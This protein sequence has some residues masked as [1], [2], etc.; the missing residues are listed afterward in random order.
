MRV[1]V[2][3]PGWNVWLATVNANG[4]SAIASLWLAWPT[5]LDAARRAAP[6]ATPL[7][8]G[9]FMPSSHL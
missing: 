4:I 9:F 6:N 2:Y 8:I 7:H 5:A 1:T 3:R